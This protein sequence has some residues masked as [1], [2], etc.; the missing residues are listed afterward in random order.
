MN[1][2]EQKFQIPLAQGGQR[3]DKVA[4]SLFSEFSRAELSRWLQE[5]ALTLD[6][7]A[8]KA[9]HKV[10]GGEWLHL[11]ARQQSREAWDEAEQIPLMY[12]MR[13]RTCCL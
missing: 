3:V 1:D 7:V 13:T 5:G 2:I 12:S 10:L 8:V 9:K 4:A 6:G 11:Q